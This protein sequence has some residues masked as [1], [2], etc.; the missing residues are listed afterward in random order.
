MPLQLQENADSSMARLN[1]PCDKRQSHRALVQASPGSI[2]N[3]LQLLPRAIPG[4]TRR[5]LIICIR[6][7][8]PKGCSAF[9]GRGRYQGRICRP[10]RGQTFSLSPGSKP[11]YSW[12][13]SVERHRVLPLQL[14]ENAD[15]SMAHL[16]TPCDKR[17]RTQGVVRASP[18]AI[19]NPLQLLL[20]ATPCATRR[21]LTILYKVAFI[22]I[23]ALWLEIKRFEFIFL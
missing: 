2:S 18:G 20:R 11:N 7:I 13:V 9:R 19:S 21:K 16:N 8:F 15:I 6:A 1:A 17:L 22:L 23:Y 5:K 14:Q 4:T 10:S 12:T 3:P